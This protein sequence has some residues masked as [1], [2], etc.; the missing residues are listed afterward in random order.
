MLLTRASSGAFGA[1]VTATLLEQWCEEHECDIDRQRDKVSGVEAVSYPSVGLERE[2]VHHAEYAT[3][4]SFRYHHV[5]H[6]LDLGRGETR[7]DTE[8]GEHRRERGLGRGAV[9]DG[10]GASGTNTGRII[11]SFTNI[12]ACGRHNHTFAYQFP[13]TVDDSVTGRPI[14]VFSR[15][16]SFVVA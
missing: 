4:R 8:T 1:S 14:G 5:G 13:S 2:F 7:I 10:A 16:A 9:S 15:S 11:R 6:R 12:A 3:I